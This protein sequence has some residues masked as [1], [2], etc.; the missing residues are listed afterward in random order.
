MQLI[1][2]QFGKYVSKVVDTNGLLDIQFSRS[3]MHP[4]KC[5]FFYELF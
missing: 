3:Y 4:Y 1:S 2:N 5:I